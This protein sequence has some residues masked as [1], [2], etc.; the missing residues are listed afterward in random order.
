M[1]SPRVVIAHDFTEAFG[2]AERVVAEMA[3]LYPEAP[4]W[5]IL[6]RSEVACQMGVSGRSSTLLPEW[7]PALRN[8]RLLAPLYPAL[9]RSRRLPACD[10]LVTSSYA[11]AH[12]FRTRNDAPQVCFC[13]SPLRF[14]WSMTASYKETWTGRATGSPAFEALAA[15]MRAVDRRTARRVSR[16]IASSQFVADQIERF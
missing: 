8:Y 5:S 4:V 3:K 6:G 9:V 13:H 7:S 2:G 11:F 16:Y 10:V 15:S 1:G 14:A 12:G